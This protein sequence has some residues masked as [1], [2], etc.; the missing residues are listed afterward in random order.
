MLTVV[1]A[2][3]VLAFGFQPVDHRV[4]VLLNRGCE[5]YQV[6][7]FRNL[8]LPSIGAADTTFSNVPFSKNRHKMAAYEHNIGWALGG[9]SLALLRQQRLGVLPPPCGPSGS[10]HLSPCCGSGSRQDP[11]SASSG[12]VLRQTH[13]WQ[14]RTAAVAVQVDVEAAALVETCASRLQS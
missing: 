13:P 9:R 7:P 6:I 3:K 5:D 4:G 11:G 10:G 1:S 14:S 8:V 12:V 2:G